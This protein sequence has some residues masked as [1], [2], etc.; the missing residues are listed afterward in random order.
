[1]DRI[2][3]RGAGGGKQKSSARTPVE[4][5]DSLRSRQY[6]RV[7]DL[8]SEGEIVGLVDG[9]KSI[10]L[11]DVP[12]QNGDG[13]FNFDGV[14]VQVRSGTQNQTH[15]EGFP[16][17]ESEEAVSAQVLQ[18]SPI[19]RSITNTN[20]DAI[21]VTLNIP[22]LVN[23]DAKTGDMTGASV[24]IAI[25]VQN[26]GGGWGQVVLDTIGGKTT[27]GYY[28]EYR[29]PLPSGGPW[30][31]RVRRVTADSTSSM[32]RN[33]TWWSSYTIIADTKL[34]YPNSALVALQVDAEQFD[35]IPTRGYHMRGRQIRV[36]SN[37][38]PTTRA[39]SGVWD[40][41]F[42][43]AYTNN[44]AW[45][46]YDIH[47]NDR[48]GLGEYIDVAQIDKWALYA[49]AQYCDELVPDGFGGLEPRFTCFLYE[50]QRAEAYKFISAL[51]SVFRG[52][53]YWALG[54]ISAVQDRPAL[55]IAQFTAASVVGGQFSYEG[56][57]G[58]S[59]HTVALVTWLDPAD[60]YRQ[61]VESVIDDEAVA[62]YGVIETEVVAVGCTSR[63]QAHRFGKW[64]IYSETHETETVTFRAGLDAARIYPGAIIQTLDPFR[65]GK[66]YGGR[67]AAATTSVLTLDAPVTLQPGVTYSVTVV[68]PSGDLQARAV[69]WAG[70][71]DTQV[72]SLALVT[73][74]SAEPLPWS[75]WVLAG[76]NLVPE[77]WRVLSSVESDPGIVEITALQHDPGKFGAVENSIVLE[78]RPVSSIDSR[79]GAVVGLMAETAMRMVNAAGMSTRI[80][81]SWM[82]P[83]AGAVA[84][85]VV[86]WRRDSE[87]WRQDTVSTTSFDIEDTPVGMYAIRIIA[88]S[89][90]GR[91]GPAVE[92]LHTVDESAVAP[93]ITGI[94]L[95]PSWSGRDCP[96][97]WGP[98]AGA[99]QYRVRVFDGATQLRED[100]TG[101]P[102]YVYTY[103]ANLADGGP[104]RAVRFEVIGFTLVGQSASPAQISVNNPPPAVPSGIAVEAGPGQ[105]AVSAIRPADPDL[106][107]MI[108]WMH[109]DDTVPTIE[110]NVIYRGGDNAYIQTGLQP[111]I[112]MYF[113]LAFVDEF[114][115]SGL[116]ISPSVSGT[117]LASG[118]VVRVT[119]LPASPDDVG[120]ELAVFLNVADQAVRG[121]YGW[122]GAAW[123]YTRDGAYLVANSVTADRIAVAN[124][125]A[126]SANLGTMMAGNMTLDALGFVRG[127]QT[128]Y[129]TGAG[130]WMG[131]HAGQYRFSMGNANQ[132]RLTFDALGLAVQGVFRITDTVQSGVIANPD[133]SNAYAGWYQ[134]NGTPV[135]QPYDGVNALWGYTTTP[136]LNTVATL[137]MD[138]VTD[139]GDPQCRSA[140]FPVAPGQI[141]N[142]TLR[143]NVQDLSTG[144]YAGTLLAVVRAHYSTDAGFAS[145]VV[146]A[147]DISEMIWQE[148]ID[149]LVG[150]DADDFTDISLSFYPPETARFCSLAVGVD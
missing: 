7:I 75:I 4:S 141:I 41:T 47:I 11:D 103:A 124:L 27:T 61:T 88:V 148:M 120:G 37:Y 14:A 43:V 115:E 13:S 91:Q 34:R 66:R 16:S 105:V 54:Q 79:P 42:Q 147:P 1:M 22:A 89:A 18:G 112:P 6:A 109:P 74:L 38:N 80:T 21:R 23:Q 137:T 26:N 149:D 104:R 97:A 86:A 90:L 48:F 133:F 139:S 108:V 67:L 117:P 140:A 45:V 122:D 24:Q 39:Y 135:Q 62:R 63:G 123:K 71:V 118:G 127:G 49:I 94:R 106:R 56:T 96:I 81:V 132:D 144:G 55:P 143:V 69:V 116:N 72:T 20:A 32:L 131:F 83:A 129:N 58:K 87:N 46:F 121:L 119:A 146:T 130:F 59:R 68:L 33:E 12:L 92:I 51:A 44:P 78:P 126:I 100:W 93:D 70:S 9:L 110:D 150:A 107:G 102:Q 64:L 136:L 99:Y 111:G 134:S 114:G 53:T 30:N 25:D 95:N 29:I 15:I 19:T 65:A 8:V 57:G 142:L 145:A 5:P 128:N 3:I 36:P 28:R 82:P 40:G 85:Y 98:L 76:S 60:R 138:G 84:R 17:V 35:R 77:Q 10:Y 52:V 2:T 31:V 50:Q 125:S 73:A 101:L 113:K